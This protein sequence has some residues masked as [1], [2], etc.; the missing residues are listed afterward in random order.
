MIDIVNQYNSIK[1]NDNLKKNKLPNSFLPNPTDDD[2]KL[3]YLVRYFV[4]KRETKGSPIFEVN[5][6][7]YGN[8]GFPYKTVF[9]NWYIS[10]ALEDIW[11]DGIYYPSIISLNSKE[12]ESVKADMPELKLYL[13]NLKQFWKPL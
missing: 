9:I 12:I 1:K 6:K 8:I 11:D 13:V 4:Q 3:G 2:Y 10:G 7:N 5:K